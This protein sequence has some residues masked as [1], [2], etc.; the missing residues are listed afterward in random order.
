[1]LLWPEN[2]LLHDP[3]CG[4]TRHCAVISVP[5]VRSSLLYMSVSCK[6]LNPVVHV[7]CCLSSCSISFWKKALKS[8]TLKATDFSTSLNF[9]GSSSLYFRPYIILMVIFN[10]LIENRRQKKLCWGRTRMWSQHPKVRFYL[11]TFS[12]HFIQTYFK[13]HSTSITFSQTWLPSSMMFLTPLQSETSDSGS[14]LLCMKTGMF[15]H[16]MLM[17]TFYHYR[18]FLS[19]LNFKDVSIQQ[20]CSFTISM[21]SLQL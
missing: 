20:S 10:S 16:T 8:L 13:V 19:L 6:T 14:A 3:I 2:I 17:T 5:V 21:I 12:A 9:V 7:L 15:H 18:A 4:Q 1:M 11:N